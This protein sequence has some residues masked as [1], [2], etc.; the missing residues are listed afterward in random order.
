MTGGEVSKAHQGQNTATDQCRE[1]RSCFSRGTAQLAPKY[2]QHHHCTLSNWLI[3]L[4]RENCIETVIRE[5]R[6]CVFG[7]EKANVTLVVGRSSEQV[8]L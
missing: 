7:T 6:A 4:L 5:N 8:H 1:E 2:S 3:A